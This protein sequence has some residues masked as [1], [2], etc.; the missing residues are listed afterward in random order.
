MNMALKLTCDN[1]YNV[2]FLLLENFTFK[3]KFIFFA[4]YLAF[5]IFPI[6]NN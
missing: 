5:I 3:G 4:S 6:C 2:D 1:N